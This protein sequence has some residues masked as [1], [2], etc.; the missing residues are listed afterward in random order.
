M[1]LPYPI[2]RQKEV[3]YLPASGNSVVLGTAGSGK[4]S[5]A[6]IRAAYLSKLNTD[7]RILLV[8]FNNTLVAYLKTLGEAD[9]AGVDIRTYHHFA[10]GYLKS[11]DKMRD[12]AIID[13]KQRLSLIELALKEV[14]RIQESENKIL[15][16][17]PESFLEELHWIAKSGISSVED[18]ISIK[19]I[20]REDS[21]VTRK[22]RP[23][24]WQ[25]FDQYRCFRSQA[26]YDYDWDD[27]SQAVYEEFTKDET[28]RMYHH[29][30]IDEGQ[31]FSPVMLRSIALAIPVD[32][33]ITFFGDM[34]QQIYGSRISWRSA[35]LNSP[36]IWYFKENYRN[37]KQIA[38]LGLAISKTAF[39]QGVSD[40]VEPHTPKADGPLPTLVKCKN[41]EEETSLI[42]K[43]AIEMGRTQ[44]VAILTRN[45]HMDD[46]FI[47]LL[48]NAQKFGIS[49]KKLNKRINVGEFGTGIFVGTYYSAKSLEFEAV[50]LPYCSAASLP[51]QSRI[52]ALGSKDEAMSEEA[53]LLYV[54][55]TRAKSRLIITYSEKITE[56]LPKDPFLYQEIEV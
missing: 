6:I 4:T 52:D 18:Y 21:R 46:T 56:L 32:G 11:R 45:R 17:S 9:L 51:D 31:D 33:G 39:F 29:V 38:Q 30:V 2:G 14:R 16:R 1:T 20:G 48:K 54:A 3:V 7:K 27:I 42:I 10:Q 47:Q 15:E 50:L 37:S 13:E 55:V 36:N 22:E 44:T 49:V 23:L 25:I 41:I 5:M 35:G 24:V 19:R 43:N 28:P 26:G 8:T 34:A 12:H 53:R 40:L